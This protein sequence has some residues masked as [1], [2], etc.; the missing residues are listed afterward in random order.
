M[1]NQTLQ[2]TRM[3]GRLCNVCRLQLAPV[4]GTLQLQVMAGPGL[5]ARRH[6]KWATAAVNTAS[7]LFAVDYIYAY[8]PAQSA[9]MATNV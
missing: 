1:E 3:L 8:C 9:G 6:A 2:V 5:G 4:Q 7:Y